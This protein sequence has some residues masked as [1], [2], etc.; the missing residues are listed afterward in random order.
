MWNVINLLRTEWHK[1]RKNAVISLLGI[2]FL[3]TM[4]TVLFIGKELKDVPPP[5]PNNKVFF[6]FPTTWDYLGYAGN[7][8]VFFF[9]GLVV[10]FLI[11]SEVNYKTMRQNVITGYTRKTYFLSKL[12]SVL[13]LCVAVTLYYMIIGLVIGFI[14]TEGA[15][16][17]SAL[18]NDYALFRFFLMSLG[19]S[20]MAFVIAFVLRKSGV[21]VLFY[22]TYIMLIEHFLKWVVHFGQIAKN[23]TIN[24]YPS[25]V[26]EDLMP[27]P[28]FH[29][30]DA[31][32]RKDLNFS[33]LLEPMEAGIATCIYIIFFIS[34]AY[35]NFMRRD[36]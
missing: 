4:P 29:F 10:I 30:A 27:F 31:I 5:L 26:I 34:I 33:F 24:F 19:Y 6:E 3:I 14:H 17:S 7:W 9:L 20:S 2:M 36:I 21:S 25:N 32:P 13:V 18:D 1:F 23:E 11:S 16:L 12:F 35:W 8:L 15:T 28:L 22:L